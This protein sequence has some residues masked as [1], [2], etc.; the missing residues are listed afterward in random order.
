MSGPNLQKR[1]KVEN[2]TNAG[3]GRPKGVPNKATI[4]IKDMVIKALDKSGGVDYL[5]KQADENPVA[6]LSLCGK[7]IPLQISNGDEP[8][9]IEI[10]RKVIGG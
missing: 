9:R 1:G 10:T 2:L 8:F 6:F 3:K 4:A 5:V 7:V